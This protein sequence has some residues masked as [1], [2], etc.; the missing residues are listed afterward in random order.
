MPATPVFNL[1]PSSSILSADGRTPYLAAFYKDKIDN[2]NAPNGVVVADALGKVYGRWFVGQDTAESIN[3]SVP[4][5]G[6]MLFKSDIAQLVVGNNILLGGVPV[7]LSSQSCLMV[8]ADGTPAKNGQAL[9]DTITRAS[10]R[11]PYG[12]ALGPLNQVTVY[13]GGGDYDITGLTAAGI[14]LPNYLRLIGLGGSNCV[15]IITSSTKRLTITSVDPTQ[16]YNTMIG[17]TFR[18][19]TP[20]SSIT[21]IN[22]VNGTQGGVLGIDL[23]HRD[24]KFAGLTSAQQCMIVTS[25]AAGINWPTYTGN[26]IECETDGMNLY[27]GFT[28]TPSLSGA[29]SIQMKMNFTRCRGGD[30]SFGGS[31]T[32]IGIRDGQVTGRILDCSHTGSGANAWC[33]KLD[34]PMVSS[35]WNPAIQRVGAN[36]SVNTSRIVETVGGFTISNRGVAQAIQIF[37][38]RLR[39]TYGNGVTNLLSTK[40]DDG[41]NAVDPQA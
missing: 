28:L 34:G 21:I 9:A 10:Q 37:S 26:A 24:L 12:L 3:A 6:E 31:S 41:G 19:V 27:G 16:F 4:A 7:N 17:I 8:A 22:G 39:A 25:Q 23:Q 11:L 40:V 35:S 14:P 38:N 18:T 1:L 13:M 2:Q 36:A 20:S 30:R 32:T 29:D 15:N 33:A 5:L